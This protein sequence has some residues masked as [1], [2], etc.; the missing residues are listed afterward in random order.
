MTDYWPKRSA[1]RGFSIE[2]LAKKYRDKLN[3]ISIDRT[4]TNSRTELINNSGALDLEDNIDSTLAEIS[5]LDKNV[6]WANR[7]FSEYSN[8]A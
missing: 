7:N 5:N 6:H 1:P 4:K 3:G 2:N 8:A